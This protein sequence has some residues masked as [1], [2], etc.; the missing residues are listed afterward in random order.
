M[1]AMCYVYV[2]NL[3]NLTPIAYSRLRDLRSVRH[4]SLVG[5]WSSLTNGRD[6]EMSVR[7]AINIVYGFLPPHQRINSLYYVFANR[8]QIFR[9]EKDEPVIPRSIS[10]P[11]SQGAAKT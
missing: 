2:V 3:V 9:P 4:P 6:I 7:N 11:R 5:P 10:V 1:Y 8:K